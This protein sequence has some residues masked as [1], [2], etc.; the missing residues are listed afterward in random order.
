MSERITT[1][2][3]ELDAMLY[4]NRLLVTNPYACALGYLLAIHGY[5]PQALVQ[6][7]HVIKKHESYL[8]ANHQPDISVN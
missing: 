6:I 1:I 7:N 4:S 2:A 8:E 5:S 3:K